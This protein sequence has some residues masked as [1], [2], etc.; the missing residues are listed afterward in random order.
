MRKPHVRYMAYAL[1]GAAA[2]V[3]MAV[4]SVGGAVDVAASALGVAPAEGTRP[5]PATPK[6]T[7]AERE[8][9]ER[10]RAARVARRTAARRARL[11]LDTPSAD[12]SP[13]DV[14][15][16]QAEAIDETSF[17]DGADPIETVA[18]PLPLDEAHAAKPAA[19]AEATPAVTPAPTPA[20]TPITAASIAAATEAEKAATATAASTPAPMATPMATPLATPTPP[21]TPTSAIIEVTPAPTSAVETANATSATSSAIP[22]VPHSPEETELFNAEEALREAANRKAAYDAASRL[23]RKEAEEAAAA[24]TAAHADFERLTSEAREAEKESRQATDDLRDVAASTTK[25]AA[26]AFE[27]RMDFATIKAE[28]KSAAAHAK[29][30]DD[31]SVSRIALHTKQ[32]NFLKEEEQKALAAKEAADAAHAEAET[33]AEA[34]SLDAINAKTAAKTDRAVGQETTALGQERARRVAVLSAASKRAEAALMQAA[35]AQ[36]DASAKHAAAARKVEEEREALDDELALEKLLAAR[37]RK[38]EQDFIDATSKHAASETQTAAEGRRAETSL[39]AAAVLDADKTANFEKAKRVVDRAQEVAELKYQAESRANEVARDL[40]DKFDIAD[41]AYE[42][43]KAAVAI[44]E[45][46]FAQA[47]NR[48][49]ELAKPD[50]EP[51]GGGVLP[52]DK[53]GD[54]QVIQGEHSAHADGRVLPVAATAEAN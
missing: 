54:T 1:A 20:P 41:A 36:S 4:V 52:L 7:A 49:Y 24:S 5:A 19:A 38:A 22:A 35:Y 10:Q 26:A 33:A 2:C 29:L 27:Q 51:E 6:M 13:M 47:E 37:S 18:T 15:L 48:A 39:F 16:K 53:V 50:G 23:A 9:A 46:T 8:A 43:Q 3:L 42:A 11:G 25:H 31:Q 12:A 28:K 30:D 40:Q 14:A 21:A 32:L 34:A 44:K 17:D 45:K